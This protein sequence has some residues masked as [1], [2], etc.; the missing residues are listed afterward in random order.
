M[1]V[2]VKLQVCV[3]KLMAHVIYLH[4]KPQ[5]VTLVSA[6][7][8]SQRWRERSTEHRSRSSAVCAPDCSDHRC[9][10]HVV[11]P[12]HSIGLLRCRAFG[13]QMKRPA[14]DSERIKAS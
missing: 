3:L 4:L 13:V 11:A 9:A 7:A 12:L 8:R 5:P 14:N 10:P 1:T 6:R 2:W